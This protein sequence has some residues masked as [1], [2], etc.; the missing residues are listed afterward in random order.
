M[1]QEHTESRP[2]FPVGAF[3]GRRF[4]RD[5]ML[6]FDRAPA[7]MDA[8][9]NNLGIR[10]PSPYS[11]GGKTY[12]SSGAFLVGELE[13]L[14]QTLHDP[15]VAVSWSRD[16]DLREDVTIADEVSSFTT[17]TFATPG[18]LGTGNGIGTGKSWIQKNTTEI[19]G[20]GLDIA[21]VTNP[22]RPWGA[23]ISYTIFELESAARLG[24]PVDAQKYDGLKLKHQ[25]DIDEQ[26]YVGDTAMGDTGLLN[27]TG[28]TPTNVPAGASGFTQW[29][30]KTAFEILADVN[31]ALTTT[32]ANAA[33]AVMPTKLLIP[34]AQYGYIST[35]P[36]TNAGSVSILRYLLENNLITK[37]GAAQLTIEPV[38]WAIGAG[39]GGTIG[40]TGTVDR[41][42]AYTM[43]KNYV[44]FPMTQLGRTPLQYSSIYHN[45]T[46]FCRLGRVEVVYPQTIGYYDGI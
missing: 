42:T 15:L 19:P 33:W 8:K 43:D 28:V 10:F 46:Y 7:G 2:I 9:G 18:G 23:E 25:M 24:R 6:T 21:K 22:L 11:V 16:I 29:V 4:T 27:A 1:I 32:W 30:N 3:R 41:M 34:P 20:I 31:T 35:E 5:N 44:R 45:T 26:V 37:S 38:K 36:V 12:D 39:A 13:R 14:D 40:T 17:S